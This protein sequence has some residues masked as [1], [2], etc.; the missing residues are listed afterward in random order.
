MSGMLE[1]RAGLWDAVAQMSREYLPSP[2]L[3]L[4]APVGAAIDGVAYGGELQ[5]R[6]RRTLY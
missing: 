4:Q 3:I 5:E 2:G 1:K 6:Q